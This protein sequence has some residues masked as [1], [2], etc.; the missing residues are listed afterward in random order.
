MS[1][2][3][4]YPRTNSP[5]TVRLKPHRC[6]A[7]SVGESPGGGVGDL[8]VWLNPLH[9]P[10]PGGHDG[11]GRFKV[12]ILVA[13]REVVAEL[14]EEAAV[15]GGRPVSGRPSPCSTMPARGPGVGDGSEVGPAGGGLVGLVTR[16]PMNNRPSPSLSASWTAPLRSPSAV[17]TRPPDLRA[18]VPGRP[19]LCAARPEHP[20]PTAAPL[21]RPPADSSH[22]AYRCSTCFTYPSRF[23]DPMYY[24]DT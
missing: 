9:A 24:T 19:V 14:R 18:G 8:D 17:S 5:W 22:L 4:P 10:H 7:E 20:T 1:Q 6:W 16:R 23:Q 11:V 21:A 12:R 3:L 15:M 2:R 13:H